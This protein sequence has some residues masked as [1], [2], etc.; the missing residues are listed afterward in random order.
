MPRI[1][2]RHTRDRICGATEF[3]D[4]HSGYSFSALQTSLDGEQ[5]LAAKR[6]FENHANQCGVRIESYRADNDRFAEKSFR[7]A[8]KLA[9]Q[10]IDFCAVGTHNQ[11]GIIER[12]FQ[13]M[14]SHARTLILHAK[15]HWP[16][17]MS[18][19]LW[20]FAYKY[21]E[22][23]YNHLHL[24]DRGRSPIEKFCKTNMK[25]DLKDIHT[26]GYP[27]YI[28]DRDLQTGS[29]IPKW[30]PRSRLGVYLGHSPCHA[31]SVALI[32]NPK[33]LHVSP[34]FHVAYD[35]SFSTSKLGKIG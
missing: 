14:S 6:Y 27:C 5:T 15:R 24:D 4:N 13:R 28:L 7:D 10:I 18:V 31:G 26:F 29:I 3:F 1:S 9:G 12:H 25:I 21:A 34:Q 35:D 16:A 17:M 22:L 23:L 8:V 19:V 20:P 30:E 11:N 33:T 32:L 2:G